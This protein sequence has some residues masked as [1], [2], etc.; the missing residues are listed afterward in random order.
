MNSTRNQ[1]GGN[2]KVSKVVMGSKHDFQNANA[3]S[4]VVES[5]RMIEEYQR[6]HLKARVALGYMDARA[7]KEED[8]DI[9]LRDYSSSDED[10]QGINAHQSNDDQNRS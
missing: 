7:A 9:E 3:N 8:E 10:D 1:N 5:P 4:S 6:C 2:E